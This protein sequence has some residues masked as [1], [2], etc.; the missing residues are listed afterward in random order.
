MKKLLFKGCATAI[1]TPFSDDG[2]IDFKS[3]ERLLKFQ[4]DNSI[5]AIVVCGTTGESATMSDDE[6]L[7]LFERTVKYV[8]GA[9][10]V[11][12]GCGSNDTKH[13]AM[14][15]HQA[16]KLGA[17]ALLH[18]TPYYNKTSQSGLEAHYAAVCAACE[19]PVIVY[20]VPS[21]TGLNIE[22]D[23]YKKLAKIENIVAVKE[24]NPNI[25]AFAKSRQLCG[26][27][28]AFYSGNDDLAVPMMSLGAFGL[29]SVLSNICPAET[30]SMCESC[31][32]GETD[33][34][35]EIQLKMFPMIEALFCEVNPIPVKYALSLMGICKQ[36]L[37]LPLVAPSSS[38]ALRVKN[39]MQALGI[40]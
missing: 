12:A 34:A 25:T 31:L 32:C 8:S 7:C 22:P 5:K 24:A 27:S 23:T 30:V 40:I 15:S 14:L 11:I 9:V 13:A 26:D 16:Q 36:Q 3:Y 17:D 19:L 21:R 4:L 39:E 18:V 29:I 38:S 6:K 33:K 28:I 35:A 2:S 20:N 1:I 10:P 37:R